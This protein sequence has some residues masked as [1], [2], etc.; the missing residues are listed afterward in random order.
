MIPAPDETIKLKIRDENTSEEVDPAFGGI[1]WQIEEPDHM[2]KASEWFWALGILALALVVFSIILKNYL[3]IIIIALAAFII[4]AIKNKKR[5]L[6]DFRLDSQGLHIDSKFYPY[7]NFESFWIFPARLE[8]QTGQDFSSQ[9]ESSTH[10]REIAF[11]F[12]KHLTPLLIIPFYNND[13]TYIRKILNRYLEE[14][15]ENESFIDLLRKKLF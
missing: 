1:N 4:Y 9:E 3:L 12:K 13:E 5:E 11:H 10:E 14:T 15:E 7:E 2:P 8:Q 6:I